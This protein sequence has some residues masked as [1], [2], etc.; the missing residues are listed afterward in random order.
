MRTIVIQARVLFIA[1]SVLS[2]V[3]GFL[4]VI[5]VREY[6]AAKTAL[7]QVHT[8]IEYRAGTAGLVKY[9]VV[10]SVDASASVI[11]L[12]TVNGATPDSEPDVLTIRISKDAIIA[13][14]TLVG[15][16]GA[17]D[18]LS[19]RI[20]LPL[21]AVRQGDRVVAFIMTGEDGKLETKALLFGNP[22]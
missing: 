14:Q 11:T 9:G 22:L 8:L 6:L 17:Y 20:P 19:T 3:V 5:A 4:G 7:A 1:L 2:I 12:K 18:S 13:R 21:S 10:G 15:Q 16:N